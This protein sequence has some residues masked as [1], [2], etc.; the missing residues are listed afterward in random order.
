[1]SE[2]NINSQNSPTSGA[3]SEQSIESAPIEQNPNPASSSAETNQETTSIPPPTSQPAI[4][5]QASG[6]SAS[7]PGSSSIPP[8]ATFDTVAGPVTNT[9]QS[10]TY[11]PAFSNLPQAN[12]APAGIVALL[13][14]AAEK[15]Q[16]RKRQKLDKIVLLAKTKGRLTN[17]DVEKLLRV[18]DATATRYLGQLVGAGR[19][20]RLNHP[21]QSVY[22]PV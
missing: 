8:A 13:K 5:Y 11:S 10:P 20:R 2:D 3:V 6:Q 4:F 14:K 1:M 19:L 12:S 15:I 21:S 18:S 9:Q 16:F 7:P 17:N 22:E